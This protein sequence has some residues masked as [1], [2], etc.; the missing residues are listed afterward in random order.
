MSFT[1]AEPVF[2]EELDRCAELLEPHLGCE[3]L[4]LLY[5]AEGQ[6]EEA[7][8]RLTQTCAGAARDFRNRVCIWQS[9]GWNGAFV[10]KQ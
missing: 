8:E 6:V 7:T 1:T 5:P 4:Q 3:L 2:R 9:C 10:R